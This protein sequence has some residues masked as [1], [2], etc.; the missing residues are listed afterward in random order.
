MFCSSLSLTLHQFLKLVEKG[1]VSKFSW[2]LS[3]GGWLSPLQGLGTCVI[4]CTGLRPVLM[5]VSLS[6]LARDH[7]SIFREIRLFLIALQGLFGL[8]SSF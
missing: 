5:A 4:I 7:V 8:A 1:L 2:F 3:P 6:G